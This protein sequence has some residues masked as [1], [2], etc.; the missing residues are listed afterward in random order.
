LKSYFLWLV[1]S[2]F[3]FLGIYFLPPP[4]LDVVTGIGI[5]DVF[6]GSDPDVFTGSDP[7]AAACGTGAWLNC[8][9]GP[10]TGGAWL[11]CGCGAWLN[12]G[13]G[14]AAPAGV[15]GDGAGAWLN[16]GCIY[17]FC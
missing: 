12:C 15:T 11:N 14:T 3:S 8:S 6:T 5:S 4:I 17:G 2:L 9:P 7:A 16:C 1:P 13:C 10:G